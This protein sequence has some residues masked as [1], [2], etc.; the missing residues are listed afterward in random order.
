MKPN[1]DDRVAR[2]AEL[3]RIYPGASSLLNFYGELAEFQKSIFEALRSNSETDLRALARYFPELIELVRQ[4]GPQPLA[5]SSAKLTAELLAEHWQGS[6]EYDPAGR[7][8]ARVLLQ[9]Y[10]EYLASRSDIHV[11]STPA[12]CPFCNARPVV[13]DRK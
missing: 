4:S 8:F 7:F 3:T 2:A 13:G 11:H 5:D 1:L 12:T 6:A 10:A 9:P